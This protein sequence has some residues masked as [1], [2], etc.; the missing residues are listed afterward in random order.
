MT[1]TL[2]PIEGQLSLDDL[3]HAPV[4]ADT[5]ARVA[6]VANDWRSDDDWQRFHAACMTASV[7]ADQTV[8]P[9]E[10]RRLLTNEHGL[11][12]EPRRLSAFWNRAGSRD[13]F[14]D[15]TGVWL[16]N[17]DRAGGN[18]GRPIRQRRLRSPRAGDAT[19]RGTE[20]DALGRVS[21]P[22]RERVEP[23]PAP[24]SGAVGP[25]R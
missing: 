6:L 12:I 3:P 1:T 17:E 14:L 18:Y 20:S 21:E 7:N 11:T 9:N 13:G 19:R 5:Q 24:R 2:D 8:D 15:Y 10:V 16:V 4:D 23:L 22:R 25:T